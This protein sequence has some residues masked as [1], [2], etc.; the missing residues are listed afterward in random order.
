MLGSLTRDLESCDLLTVDE[1]G[2]LPLHRH[3]AELLFIVGV[4]LRSLERALSTAPDDS[5]GSHPDKTLLTKMTWPHRSLKSDPRCR[6]WPVHILAAEL[7]TFYLPNRGVLYPEPK[8]LNSTDFCAIEQ[9]ITIWL[10]AYQQ[11]RY[12][13]KRTFQDIPI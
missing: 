7:C 4:F 10:C 12:G 5:G 11:V 3:A 13:S 2:F 8:H 1:P 6:G 9:I